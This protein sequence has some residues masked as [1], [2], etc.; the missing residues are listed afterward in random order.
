MRLLGGHNR[1][2]DPKETIVAP[3]HLV[4]KSGN[5]SPLSQVVG[6]PILIHRE[7]EEQPLETPND[8]DLDNQAVT[9]MMI[10]P[11]SGFAPSRYF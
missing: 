8:C 11:D 7:T 4:W 2:F 1:P 5:I 6:V 10:D 9:Y 3:D